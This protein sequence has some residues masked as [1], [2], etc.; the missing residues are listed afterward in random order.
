MGVPER[1]PVLLKVS[2]GGR[3][4]GEPKVTAPAAF[5][6]VKVYENGVTRK[7]SGRRNPVFYMAVNVWLAVC[8]ALVAVKVN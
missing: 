5:N 3:L 4:L 8:P 2:P 1:T 6:G 7:A